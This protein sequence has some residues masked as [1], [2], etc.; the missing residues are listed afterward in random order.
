MQCIKLLLI[1]NLSMYETLFVD[2][3]LYPPL[4]LDFDEIITISEKSIQQ[5]KRPS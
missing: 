1:D 2:C 3:L 4:I 5:V